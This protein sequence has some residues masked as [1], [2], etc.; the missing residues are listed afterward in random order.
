MQKR[1]AAIWFRYLLTDRYTIREPAL[2]DKPFVLAS[3]ERGRMIVRAANMR[4][5]KKG[6][7]TGMVVADA[8]AVLPTLQ[9]MD[10]VSGMSDKLLSALAKWSIRYTPVVAVD[11]PD[12]LILDVSG[13]AH[14]WGGEEA[15]IKDILTRLKK[16]GYEVHAAIADT[17]GTAWAIS[18]YGEKGGIVE[19]GRQAEALF[20]LPP[21]ALRLEQPVLQRLD[22]LGLTNIRSFMNMPRQALRRRFGQQL[23]TRLD[24]ALGVEIEPIE[25]VIP[26]E[27]FQERLPLFDPVRT[28]TGIEIAIQKLLEALCV[29]LVKEGKGLRVAVLKCFRVDGKLE[30]VQISTNRPTRNSIHLFKLFELKIASIEPDLGIE[31]FVMEAPVIE[32]VSPEQEKLWNMS[33]SYNNVAVAELLD[34]I[35]GKIG[36]QGIRRYLPDE[37]YLPERSVRLAASLEEE[38]AIAWRTDL[39]R[40]IHLLSKPEPIQVTV[41]IPDYPPM[42][43]EYKGKLHKVSKADGPERI[44]QEWWLQAGLYRDYYCVEDEDGS[45]YWLF[46][47]GSYDKHE[48]KWF[49]HGFFA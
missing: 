2:R 29:R 41:P 8:R 13:C 7:V 10:E 21:A 34:A 42:N 46:R 27:P 18:R 44:E 32:D 36:A 19:P 14:L 25:P 4:A 16:A 20:S 33:G 22:K 15:Y 11:P 49:V 6:I 48:P 39:P 9:V 35:A 30:Q 45:R 24:Q 28:A 47:S 31:L 26:I 40:P 1:F 37:H 23:L 43:F 38:P 3:P 12:G 17:A 5:E